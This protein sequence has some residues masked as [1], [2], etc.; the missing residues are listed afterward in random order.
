MFCKC[1]CVLRRK[2]S[3]LLFLAFVLAAI[4]PVAAQQAPAPTRTDVPSY[5]IEQFLKTVNFRGASFAP[6]NSK[7]LVGSDESGVFN[8]YAIAVSSGAATQLTDSTKESINPIRY[9]PH[10]ERFL[11]TSDQGGNELN[12]VYVQSPDGD[13]HDLTPGENLK[14]RFF[15]LAHDDKSFY[16]STNERDQR[17]FDVYEYQ[18]TDL[19]AATPYPREMIYQNDDGYM[20]AEISR[21]GRKI[22]LSK[23]HTRDNSDVY[24]Y[25]RDT[26]ETRLIT[27]HDGE[28]NYSAT[29]FSPD[30]KSIYLR[31][32]DGSEFRYLVKQDLETGEREEILR[33]D[34]DVSFANFS[35]QGNYLLVG[36]NANARTELSIYQAA[37]MQPVELPT[38]AGTSVDS[39]RLSADEK[40][41]A[42]YLSS[43]RIPSDLYYLTMGSDQP[44]KLTN[45]LNQEINPDYLVDGEVVRFA[46]F[47]GVEIPGIL[48]VPHQAD[49]DHKVPALVWVHGGPG[50]Q[51][52]IGYRALIQYLVNHGYVVYAINNR[53]SSGYGKSFQQLDDQKHGEGDLLDC[54]ASKQML[55]QTGVV[56]RDRIGIIGGSYG[57]YMVLAALAFQPQEFA[58]GVDIFGVANWHRTV[59]NIPPWWEARRASLEKE[60]GDFDDEEYFKQISPLFHADKIRSPLMVLQGANDPRVLQVESDE[61]VAAV[62]RNGVPVEYLVF[63]DEGHGFRKKE[64]QEQA[65]QAILS[66]LDEQ[67]RN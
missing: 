56:D 39:V 43:D 35:K 66:F 55:V 14:A 65:Y 15:G 50:G 24:L 54:V 3:R 60:M 52:R 64:N 12:H 38:V 48:Y 34:W 8:A 13:V 22:A 4:V 9:F 26:K 18:I 59:K 1:S 51:S 6:D 25:D 32:D 20:P 28:V 40:H 37:T 21:D 45:S 27:E 44:V 46:S 29:T 57:G 67:L 36:V 30:G 19:D 42:M 31:T 61:M 41:V 16:L 10:D 7:L 33:P 2:S 63:A 17:F 53:G 23:I 49:A 11:F 47:D 5:T 58:V 62:K